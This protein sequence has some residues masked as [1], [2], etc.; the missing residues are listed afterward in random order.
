MQFDEV[1]RAKLRTTKWSYPKCAGAERGQTAVQPGCAP[2]QCCASC[3][4]CRGHGRGHRTLPLHFGGEVTLETQTRGATCF[5][6][7]ASFHHTGTQV[8]ASLSL[9]TDAIAGVRSRH[10]PSKRPNLHRFSLMFFVSSV[11]HLKQT[12]DISEAALLQLVQESVMEA[13]A[14]FG[15]AFRKQTRKPIVSVRFTPIQHDM[16]S[17]SPP[18]PSRRRA[19]L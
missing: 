12:P 4:S 11:A 5:Q 7:N 15:P 10:G 9:I 18:A 17:S 14:L 1:Q 3:A 13:D 8:E 2:G 16:H 6:S 19:R